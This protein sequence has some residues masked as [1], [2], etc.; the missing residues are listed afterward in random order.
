MRGGALEIPPLVKRDAVAVGVGTGANGGVAGRGHGV[1]VIVVAI[2]E[3]GAALEEE[4]E[5]V[6]GLEVVAEAI[7]VVATKLVENKDYDELWPGAV[8]VGTKGLGCRR[9]EKTGEGGHE[10]S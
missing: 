2:G 9:K 8:G 6:G 3:V 10:E 5:A 4:I 1:G 7:E